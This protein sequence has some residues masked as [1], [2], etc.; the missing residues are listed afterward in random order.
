M[1]RTQ[2]LLTYARNTQLKIVVMLLCY[3]LVGLLIAAAISLTLAIGFAP[4][5][6]SIKL[7]SAWRLFVEEWDRI[8]LGGLLWTFIATAMFRRRV[9]RI[10]EATAVDRETESRL[11]N[12]VENLAISV[13]LPVPRINVVESAA[14]N[15][16]ISGFSPKHMSLTFTRG[17][18]R[19]LN[20]RQLSAIV[21]HQ[22]TLVLSGE[23]RKLSLAST[24]TGISIFAA[25]WLVKPFYKFS[26]RT[27]LII[28]ALPIFPYAMAGALVTS[29]VAAILGAVLL[30]LSVSKLRIYV[31][32]AGA[33]ELTKDAEALVSALQ[34]MSISNVIDGADIAL[35]PLL[36]VGANGRWLDM[37]PSVDERIAAIH[38]YVPAATVVAAPLRLTVQ[39]A[40][41]SWRDNFAIPQWVTGSACS[42]PLGFFAAYCALTSQWSAVDRKAVQALRDD[43]Q[44][45]MEFGMGFADPVSARF[46]MLQARLYKWGYGLELDLDAL[47]KASP[48][49]GQIALQQS[50]INNSNPLQI[51]KDLTEFAALNHQQ[52]K[53][54]KFV[55]NRNASPE[56]MAKDVNDFVVRNYP[57]MKKVE[58]SLQAGLL[59]QKQPANEATG[60]IVP[61]TDQK[62]NETALMIQSS[63]QSLGVTSYRKDQAHL[64]A[65]ALKDRSKLAKAFYDAA[66]SCVLKHEDSDISRKLA[67]DWAG[68]FAE[69]AS[70]ETFQKFKR[71]PLDLEIDNL[72]RQ[73]DDNRSP[74]ELFDID[75]PGARELMGRLNEK[76]L[77]S[78]WTSQS[79]VFQTARISVESWVSVDEIAA[80]GVRKE[81]IDEMKTGPEL[82]P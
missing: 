58:E 22:F 34:T 36:F 20:D 56:Q 27:L 28:L 63:P 33:L 44:V 55:P 48:I 54:P 80:L 7:D 50:P 2:G 67:L 16:L 21:A 64:V 3:I 76:G 32:D 29:A 15:A 35:Q 11:Y 37:H 43:V 9:E 81:H 19:S 70:S 23:A 62:K 42:I 10:L 18:L 69:V 60:F 73:A 13:G 52:Q 45:V 4:G 30:K 41:P 38:S 79:C 66:F 75:A 82:S 68:G 5:T 1:L 17:A 59:G 40:A 6:L 72:R 57:Q 78:T 74:K 65:A 47:E 46:L 24:L 25:T 8:L 77:G 49:S 53:L 26:F 61:K 31:C 71:F 39:Q 51:A 12:I 14:T